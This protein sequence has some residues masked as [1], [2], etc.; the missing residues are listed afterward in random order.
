[1]TQVDFYIHVEDKVRTAARLATK[2]YQHGRRLTVF[3]PDPQTAQQLDRMLWTSPAIGFVPHCYAHEALAAV[4]PVIIDHDG[5]G[6]SNDDI[7]LNLG[8]ERPALFGRFSRLIEIVAAHDEDR[9]HARERFKFYRDRGYEIRT[10][11]MS[12]AGANS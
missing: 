2:A 4:T 5:S 11:D 1:M 7:L 10:H 3:C 6:T 9:R 12:S 8:D